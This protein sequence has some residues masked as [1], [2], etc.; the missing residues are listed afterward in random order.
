MFLFRSDILATTDGNAEPEARTIS[1]IRDIVR[2]SLE[3][4]DLH[5]LDLQ[6]IQSEDLS[7]SQLGAV[8]LFIWSCVFSN[9]LM[10]PLIQCVSKALRILAKEAA[11]RTVSSNMH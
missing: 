8:V 2:E 6:D 1:W 7:L 3:T 9:N 4:L 10:W 5:E 11:V